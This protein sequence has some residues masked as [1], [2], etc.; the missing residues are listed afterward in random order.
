MEQPHEPWPDE[1]PVYDPNSSADRIAMAVD[2]LAR[3]PRSR[4]AHQLDICVKIW[5]ELKLYRELEAKAR[6]LEPAL[7]PWIN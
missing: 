3:C 2:E 5:N 7:Q 4:I 1:L 6:L